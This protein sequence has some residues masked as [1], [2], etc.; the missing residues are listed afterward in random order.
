MVWEGMNRRKFPRVKFPCLVKI[1]HQDRPADVILTHTENIS[2][3][4][5]CVVIKKSLELF[6]PVSIEI[7]LL[8]SE[9][10]IAC[11][12][13]TIWAIRRKATETVKPSYYDTGFE[14]VDIKEADRQ[15]IDRTVE[16]FLK[17]QLKAKIES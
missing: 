3:G 2:G 11:K 6:S 9:D 17:S 5:V 13:R 4:G 16:H 10:V 7:D 14:Y 1:V 15:R 8:D 12:G